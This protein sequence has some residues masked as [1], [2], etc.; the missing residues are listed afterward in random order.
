MRT[1]YKVSVAIEPQA[2][3][4]TVELLQELFQTSGCIETDV[5]S[6]TTQVSVFL[7]KRPSPAKL[8][9][10]F[11][12]GP[13]PSPGLGALPSFSIR[14]LKPENWAESW[15]RH[16]KAIEIDSTLLIKPSWSRRKPKRDQAVVVLDPGLSFGTGQHPTTRFCLEQIVAFRT[17]GQRQSFL[18]VGTGSGILAIAAAKLGYAPVEAFDFDPDAVRIARTNIFHNHVGRKIRVFQNDIT[19]QPA[20]AAQKYDVI[21]ANLISDLLIAERKRLVKQLKPGGRLVLAGILKL[22]FGDVQRMYE[23]A[24]LRLVGSRVENEWRSGAFV[25]NSGGRK[26]LKN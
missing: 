18:D 1:L 10:F 13:V 21:C 14:K 12:V 2:E 15:K 20:A 6:N 4:A 25:F 26:F 8:R 23:N 7:E 22:Q 19:S 17:A 16:F 24:G 11:V 5:E 9:S 3:E